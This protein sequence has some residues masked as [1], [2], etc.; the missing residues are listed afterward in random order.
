MRGPRSS[1]VPSI[2]FSAMSVI[3]SVG[4]RFSISQAT[5]IAN[6]LYGISEFIR[7]LPSERDQNLLFR[8]NDGGEFILKIANRDEQR[9]T[10]DLQNQAMAHVGGTGTVVRTKTGEQITT[11]DGH[12][13]RLVNYIPGVPL[14][15]FRPH[16]AA[17]LTELGR[18]LG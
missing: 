4:P 7:E 17:L 16:S 15:E 3:R 5:E 1:P 6:N 10:L 2:M 18:M 11:V 14:A 8:R 9:P 12:F 13:I